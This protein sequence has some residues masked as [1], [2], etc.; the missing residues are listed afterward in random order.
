VAWIGETRNAYKLL[1]RKP[2]GKRP[3]GRSRCREDNMNIICIWYCQ[4]QVLTGYVAKS[5]SSYKEE[6]SCILRKEP[7]N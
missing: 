3:L 1:V 7:K 6:G 5:H 4:P 2:E